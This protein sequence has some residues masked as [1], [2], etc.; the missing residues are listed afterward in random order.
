[1]TTSTGP[2]DPEKAPGWLDR[3]DQRR[4]AGVPT[5]SVLAGPVGLG[6]RCWQKWAYTRQRSVLTVDVP[7]LEGIATRW[8]RFLIGTRDLT[9]DARAFLAARTGRSP[10]ELA[11]KSLHELRLLLDYGPMGGLQVGAAS[12]CRWL[13][14]EASAGRPI[15]AKDFAGRLDQ[16]LARNTG[17]WTRLLAALCDLIPAGTAPL[18]LCAPKEPDGDLVPWVEV[19]AL[20][21]A[22]IAT[23][24]AAL[25]VGLTV[26]ADAWASYLERTPESHSKAILRETVIPVAGLDEQTLTRHLAEVQG[27]SPGDFTGSLRRLARDGTSGELAQLFAEAASQAGFGMPR[28]PAQDDRA[29]SAAERFLFERLESLTST[30]GLFEL[31]AKMGFP[32]GPREAEV[33]LACRDL[34]LAIEI[35]GHYHF[36][37]CDAYRR[38]RRKDVELQRRG[39]LVLRFLAEDVVVRLEEILDTILTAMAFRLGSD[40]CVGRK[41]Q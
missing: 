41:G 28:S 39:Y 5:V 13:L 17:S 16:A 33:D 1:M 7:D 36:Q 37:D 34:L 19:A 24:A 2:A 20:S 11:H 22:Q 4:Q 15:Q 29:R 12:A 10:A 25:P 23:A 6:I 31:N 27:I 30:V 9:G 8:A 35:D 40:V 21:L 14:E 18:I 32:F 3:H 38:D 26:P